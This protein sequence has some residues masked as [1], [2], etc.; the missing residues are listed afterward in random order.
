MAQD[1]KNCLI[2]GRKAKKLSQAALAEMLFISPQ[3]VGKWERG[4]SLP[5]IIMLEKLAGIFGTDLNFF[6]IDPAEMKQNAASTCGC[7]PCGYCHE[8]KGG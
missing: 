8:P 2:H 7:C 5:D 3:A 6:A 1:L 4:E